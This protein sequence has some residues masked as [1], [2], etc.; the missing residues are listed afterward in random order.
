MRARGMRRVISSPRTEARRHA[1]RMDAVSLLEAWRRTVARDPDARAVIDVSGA[2]FT[3]RDL[4]ARAEQW[5]AERGAQKL[6]GRRVM[7]AE[8][9]GVRW[10]E[11]FL[12][13]M[14]AGAIPVP[15]DASEPPDTLARIAPA[16]NAAAVWR[17]GRWELWRENA[18]GPRR[19]FAL[20]KLTSGSTG[21]PRAR[22]FTHAQML[23]DAAQICSSMGIAPGDLNLAVIPL[24]H[25]YGLGNLVVPLLVQ[26]TAVLCSASPL[27]HAIAADCARWRP[28]VFPAVPT[29]LRALARAEVAPESLASLRLVISAGAPLSAEVASAFAQ[30]FARKVH[31]FYGSTETGGITFDR[32]GD[33]AL[34]GRSVGTPLDGVRLRMR[35][36]GRFTVESAAVL[37][38]GAFSPPDRAALD[39]RG[40]LVLHG[41]V[42]RTIKV[43]ARRLDPVEVERA[44]LALPEVRGA[45]VLPHPGR[46]DAIA[47]IVATC[48]TPN[49]LRAALARAVAPWKI[50][51]RFA[52]VPELPT[53]ARGKLDRAAIRRMLGEA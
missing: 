9:N 8:P 16:L 2:V 37:G 10:F 44:L 49:T 40:E 32:T 11:V 25:S 42:G 5:N 50:P 12:G 23:A 52:V 28:T 7:L 21:I 27:P 47:A 17:D 29:L 4:A 6:G 36:G 26:G 41:R 22:A 43:G 20:I 48:A 35:A 13:L 45:L 39:E 33:A 31:N 46:A 19:E 34:T 30:R 3:R 15:V 38:R 14:H 18:R 24:G 51:E 53:T 1:E